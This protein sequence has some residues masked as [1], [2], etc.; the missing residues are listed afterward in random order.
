MTVR[1]P[2]TKLDLHHHLRL[3]PDT[4]FHFLSCQS[5]D[6]CFDGSDIQFNTFFDVTFYLLAG[7]CIL[8]KR[9]VWIVPITLL[10]ALNRETS[11]LIP[12]LLMFSIFALPEGS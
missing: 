2:F 11:G 4:V 10:A 9:F 7:L 1:R 12:F 5:L 6:D 3:D 8:Q